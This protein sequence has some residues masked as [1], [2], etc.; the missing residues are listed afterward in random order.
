[1]ALEPGASI[2][3]PDIPDFPWTVDQIIEEFYGTAMPDNRADILPA[4]AGESPKAIAL[5]E[6]RD[7]ATQAA[8]EAAA[9][10]INSMAEVLSE[11]ITSRVAQIQENLSTIR[12]SASQIVNAYPNLMGVKTWLIGY[13]AAV[14][15]P[16]E[17]ELAIMQAQAALAALAGTAPTLAAADAAALTVQ[18][19]ADTDISTQISMWFTGQRDA[20]ASIVAN[21][22]AANMLIQTIM[23]AMGIGRSDASVQFV[24]ALG[25]AIAALNAA[26][27]AL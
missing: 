22:V 16:L 6:R 10:A 3:M 14:I 4:V 26:V 8:N 17:T 1:M 23:A 19:Q 12:D 11:A 21:C 7:N 24:N 9:A 2:P 15:A 5:R 25:T 18:L 13:E 20:L 27:A